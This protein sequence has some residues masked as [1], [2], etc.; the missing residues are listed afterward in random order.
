MGPAGRTG[1]DRSA[2]SG[3]SGRPGAARTGIRRRCS[4]AAGRG[5][6]A[7]ANVLGHFPRATGRRAR[8][9]GPDTPA[10][11][12][13]HFVRPP[14]TPLEDPGQAS[15]GGTGGP[16]VGRREGQQREAVSAAVRS[17][18]FAFED[19]AHLFG[20]VQPAQA[21]YRSSPRESSNGDDQSGNE[22]HLFRQSGRLLVNQ[23]VR[24]SQFGTCC[25]RLLST[26]P[27]RR[28]PARLS[29]SL[30]RWATS[31]RTRS[32][33]TTITSP[34]SRAASRVAEPV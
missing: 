2:P 15:V 23:R 29:N 19:P 13:A 30:V 8:Q 34:S 26:A 25:R 11:Q 21:G 16:A 4:A 7:P 20:R 12:P 28:T 10:V 9:H 17:R 18:P 22:H 5:G 32:A 27:S 31:Q 1:P 6:E 24:Y 33:S 14:Q 3:L